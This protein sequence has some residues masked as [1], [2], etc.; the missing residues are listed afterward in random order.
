MDPGAPRSTGSATRA[1]PGAR[2]GDPLRGGRTDSLVVHSPRT[3]SGSRRVSVDRQDVTSSIA[4][5]ASLILPFKLRVPTPTEAC[6]DRPGLIDV[7]PDPMG[8][9]RRVLVTGPAGAGKTTLLA[10]WCRRLEYDALVS[11][12]TIDDAD[13]DPVRLWAHLLHGVQSWSPRLGAEAVAALEGGAPIVDVVL[14]LLVRDLSA[15]DCP[16]VLVLDDLHTLSEGESRASLDALAAQIPPGTTLAVSSRQGLG[17]EQMRWVFNEQA[18]HVSG[19]DLR[20]SAEEIARLAADLSTVDV[21]PSEAA[22]LEHRTGGWAA[23]LSFAERRA[24]R[25]QPLHEVSLSRDPGW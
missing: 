10:T 20:F 18:Q 11:W 6:I 17:A 25:A 4:A 13:T 21:S 1:E 3:G 12:L 2:A 5:G 14:P 23:P 15:M 16:A 8:P 7:A 22:M 19:D 9:P 24:I